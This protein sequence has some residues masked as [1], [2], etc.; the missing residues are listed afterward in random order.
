MVHGGGEEAPGAQLEAVRRRPVRVDHRRP[1]SE[2]LDVY[3][4]ALA[5]VDDFLLS[6]SDKDR[7]WA[8]A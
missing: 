3:G 4:V 1:D 6:G 7:R 8:K 2:K 5:H